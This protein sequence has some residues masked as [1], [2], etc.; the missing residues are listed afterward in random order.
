MCVCVCVSVCLCLCLCVCVCVCVSVFVVEE[1]EKELEV[2]AR[3][4]RFG[5]DMFTRYQEGGELRGM[6]GLGCE[7][8]ARYPG[9]WMMLGDCELSWG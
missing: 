9:F 6:R 3:Y 8:F 7:V 4:Q 1:G 2:F 5:D